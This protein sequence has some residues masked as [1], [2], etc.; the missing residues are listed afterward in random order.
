MQ[1]HLQVLSN[2]LH[3]LQIDHKPVS[4][5]ILEIRWTLHNPSQGQVDA[6]ELLLQADTELTHLFDQIYTQHNALPSDKVSIKLQFEGAHGEHFVNR[7]LRDNPLRALLARLERILQSNEHVLLGDW[8]ITIDIHHNSTGGGK[9]RIHQQATSSSTSSSSLNHMTHSSSSTSNVNQFIV[10]VQEED[11]A[12][13]LAPRSGDSDEEMD[14][15]L[16]GFIVS[17]AEP[18]TYDTSESSS[19]TSES[20]SSC[21]TPRGSHFNTARLALYELP[22]ALFASR[23]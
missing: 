7:F 19:R 4:R 9:R 14:D 5:H 3:Q 16:D 20:A 1:F 6:L 11:P 23:V 2:A 21:S 12:G 10:Q 18:L 22:R 13:N 17:D 15:D 8:T